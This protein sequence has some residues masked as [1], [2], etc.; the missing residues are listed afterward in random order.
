MAEALIG[1]FMERV[2]VVVPGLKGNIVETNP[3]FL[4]L[5]P[6]QESAWRGNTRSGKKSAW[7]T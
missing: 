1:T 5:A 3:S 6:L 2:K 7:R 4:F